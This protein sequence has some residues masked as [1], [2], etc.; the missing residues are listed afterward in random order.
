MLQIG[1]LTHLMIIQ[2]K[3]IIFNY[4]FYRI[5]N[6]RDYLKNQL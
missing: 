4:I 3:K 5:K 2:L 6:Q 1:Y